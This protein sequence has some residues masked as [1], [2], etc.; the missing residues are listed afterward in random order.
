MVKT[1]SLRVLLTGGIKPTI[2]YGV[3]PLNFIIYSKLRTCIKK[4]GLTN[5]YNLLNIGGK[6]N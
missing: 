6:L 5:T 1:L 3:L 4:Y 2:R